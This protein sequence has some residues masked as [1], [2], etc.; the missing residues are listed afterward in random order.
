MNV[1]NKIKY[2]S[3]VPLCVMEN[4]NPRAEGNVRSSLFT[5][6]AG[7]NLASN[8]SLFTKLAD[9][10]L[11]KTLQLAVLEVLRRRVN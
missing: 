8:L 10:Y 1:Y 3:Y 2:L 7:L 9:S 11:Q 6:R 5:N 4:P